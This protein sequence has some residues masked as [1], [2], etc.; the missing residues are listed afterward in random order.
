MRHPVQSVGQLHS[1]SSPPRH[2]SLADLV[3]IRGIPGSG[4][5]TMAEVLA[6]IG[7]Y[8][9]EADMYFIRDGVYRYDRL[10]I[11][12]A[13]AWCRQKTADALQDGRKVV[14]SNT[15]TQLRE[16]EPYLAL[17][18]NVQVIE[19][20]GRWAN[21]HGVPAETLAAMLRRW[22]QMPDAVRARLPGSSISEDQSKRCRKDH[23]RETTE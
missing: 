21:R 19:A 6:E 18:T 15:F 20:R 10:E 4:K 11:G 23:L 8:H 14:V 7:Y 13:H 9:F 16:I 2:S 22:E 12:K 5:S 1:M 3:L 17:T